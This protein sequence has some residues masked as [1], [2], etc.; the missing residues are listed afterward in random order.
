MRLILANNQS[1]PFVAFHSQLQ[2]NEALYEYSSYKSLL[3]TFDENGCT[4]T[5]LDTGRDASDYQG[6]Y[7]NGYMRIPE[8]AFSAATVLDYQ[9]VPFVNSEL[10][11]APSLTKLSGYAKLS[12]AG[13]R[14]P[15]TVAGVADALIRASE[16]NKLEAVTYPCILK[17]ADADR[18]IDNFILHSWELIQEKLVASE[19]D[20]IWLIQEY[21]PNDG[22]YVSTYYHDQLDFGIYRRYIERKDGD[23]TKSHLFKPKGGANATFLE[24][25]DVPQNVA[26]ISHAAARAM[27]REIASVDVVCNKHTNEPFVLEVNYNPQLVTV[28]TFR[29]RRI[30]SF[31]KA[32]KSIE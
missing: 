18:G 30:E 17:R 28:S 27:K 7:L 12:A 31:V 23:D 5:N 14:L 24:P 13:I 8:L 21:I 16:S 3:F 15:R 25:E 20:S 29:D 1:A 9:K 6:V 11:D 19:E 26:E 32:I 22:F 2:V 4:F 10:R